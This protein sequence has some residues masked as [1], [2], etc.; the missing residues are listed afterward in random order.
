M[1]SRHIPERLK[2]KIYQEANMT[3]PNC[4][5]RDVSTFEIHHIQPF[6]DVKKHEERNLILLCSNCHSKATVGELTEIEVL[7]LK[8]GLISSSSGQSKETMPSNV[9]T[10]DSVKN[11]GVIANQVT[12]NNSPAKVVLLPAVG[13]IASSLKHQNYIKYL[14]DK[15]HA[16][17]I[18]EVGKSNMKYPVFY[19]ALKRK[20]GAKWDMV[21]IDRFLE[22]STYIQ[23]RIEKTVL[24]KKLKAQGKKSYS[25]FEEYL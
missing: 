17:K 9:I 4:G 18:V 16:Y 3:C 1:V 2:K 14:I 11:H 25:T 23:D 13:S 5:E 6:V 10:L 19:N 21:P 7:R 24:G 8:V 15:Y 22:L 20:F 12:L